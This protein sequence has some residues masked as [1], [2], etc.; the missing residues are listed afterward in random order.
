M[1]KQNSNVKE[2]Q[3]GQLTDTIIRLGIL[4]LIVYWC[5]SI[6][7]PFILVLVWAVVIAIAMYPI[8]KTSVKLFRGRTK[9]PIVI[10][11]MIL[12]SLIIVPS[13]LVTESLYEGVRY[14]TINYQKGL[15]I[16]PAPNEAT[17]SWPSFT[18]P[19]LD[20]W[21]HASTNLQETVVKYSDEVTKV[22]SW[23]LS[24]FADIGKGI[25]QF[26]VSILIAGFLLAFSEHL[27]GVSKK[28]FFKIAGNKGDHFATI[29]VT[30]IQNVVKGFLG[31]AIIQAAMAGLGFF[32]AGVPFAGLWS[33]ACLVLAVVQ[34]GIGPVAV[35]IAIY[36]FS[37]SDTTTA[38]ILSIWLLITL[39]IDNVLKPIILGKNAPVPMLV[40]FL[41]AIGGFILSGFLGLFL[42]AVVLTIGYKLLL[43]WIE[44]EV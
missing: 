34:I 17:A 19:V 1:D 37:V 33:V 25:L 14:L 20:I 31:V 13:F 4:F 41:G 22:G 26:N 38:T 6:L 7:K 9:V 30:T 21:Q 16:I 12:L 3:F 40:V 15:P 8:Y 11:T 27:K 32:I 39:M 10:L 35:P 29:T 2:T 18:K 44:I 43:A 5:Y 28:V 24:A 36:M 23:I 42:G